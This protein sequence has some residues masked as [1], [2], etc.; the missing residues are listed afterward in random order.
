MLVGHAEAGKTTLMQRLT[1]DT[2][3]DK[4]GVTDGINVQAWE[5]ARVRPLRRVGFRR[6]AIIR[7]HPS[8]LLQREMHLSCC[9]EPTNGALEATTSCDGQQ[10]IGNAPLTQPL[11]NG[12]A[13][14]QSH[15][16]ICQAP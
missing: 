12:S 5:H 4:V 3:D 16:F 8:N 11:C 7:T 13:D 9:V 6:S 1:Y 10:T 2:F 14:R 15:V